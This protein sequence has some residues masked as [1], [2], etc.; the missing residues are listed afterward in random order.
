MCMRAAHP[1]LAAKSERSEKRS[2]ELVEVACCW[3]KGPFPHIDSQDD[4]RRAVEA[5]NRDSRRKVEWVQ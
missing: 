3:S 2:V 5:W 1:L 4:E